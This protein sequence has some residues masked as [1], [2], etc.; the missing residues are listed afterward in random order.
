MRRKSTDYVIAGI[1]RL[2][3]RRCESLIQQK[4]ILIPKINSKRISIDMILENVPIVT[5]IHYI[6]VEKS[7]VKV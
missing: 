4:L 7:V 1:I 6:I 3:E 2:A 5:N